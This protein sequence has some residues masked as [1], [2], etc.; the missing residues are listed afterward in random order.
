MVVNEIYDLTTVSPS[1]LGAT[2]KSAI[3]NSVMNW[4]SAMK[5]ADVTSTHTAIYPELPGG[6][7]RDPK[8]LTYYSFTV[9]GENM[10]FADS[11]FTSV[12]SEN[13]TL[14][15]TIADMDVNGQNNIVRVLNSLGY[16][17]VSSSLE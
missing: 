13:R 5:E 10:V 8:K 1:I 6:S 9:N 12:I 16:F 7:E 14:T 15:I 2:H 4:E 17:N 11:W 3:L